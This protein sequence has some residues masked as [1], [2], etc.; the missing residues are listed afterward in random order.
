MGARGGCNFN[1][2]WDDFLFLTGLF[3]PSGRQ[4]CRIAVW[5]RVTPRRYRTRRVISG[6]KARARVCYHYYRLLGM[7]S[8][9]LRIVT[10]GFTKGQKILNLYELKERERK[11]GQPP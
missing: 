9:Q 3:W 6:R 7:R 4:A 8:Q 2:P 5:A 10:F 11:K 1:R